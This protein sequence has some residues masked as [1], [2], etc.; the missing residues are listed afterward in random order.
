VEHPLLMSV[1]RN[2]VRVVRLAAA[3]AADSESHRP[4]TCL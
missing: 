3:A 2:D 4:I 1:C